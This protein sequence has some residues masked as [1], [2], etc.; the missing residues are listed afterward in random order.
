MSNIITWEWLEENNALYKTNQIY[1]YPAPMT[2]EV[3]IEYSDIIVLHKILTALELTEK[4]NEIHL[5]LSMYQHK[6]YAEIIWDLVHQSKKTMV[7]KIV[8]QANK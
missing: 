4:F 1:I 3:F 7:D 2:R 5:E 6:E 8:E